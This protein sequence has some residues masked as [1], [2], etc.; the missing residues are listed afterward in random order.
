MARRYETRNARFSCP[1]FCVYFEEKHLR[2][3]LE[4]NERVVVREPL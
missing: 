2:M 4:I 1:P 3:C